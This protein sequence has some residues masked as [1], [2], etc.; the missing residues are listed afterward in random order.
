INGDTNNDFDVF[1]YDRQTGHTVRA[2]IAFNGAEAN[3][4]SGA[5]SISTDGR[6]VTFVSWATNLVDGDT[7][8]VQDIFVHDRGE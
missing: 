2:S 5:A 8:L 4:G 1:V 6:Y 3:G 7:N